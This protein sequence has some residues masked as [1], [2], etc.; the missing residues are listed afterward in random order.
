MG[1]RTGKFTSEPKGLIDQAG[2]LESLSLSNP[3]E[4]AWIEVIH[5]MDSVYADL[6]QSQV[7]L[8]K[9]HD[10]LKEAQRFISS[11]L[12][13]MTEVLI[14]CDIDGVIQQTNSALDEITGRSS[15]EMCGHSLMS[16]FSGDAEGL[17]QQLPEQV[18]SGKSV[19]DCEVSLISRDGEA[20][21]LAVNC[22]SRYNSR[23]KLVG[24][25]LI[26]RPLG[27]LRQAYK[28][29][30]QAHHELRRTQQQLILSEK[31][32][33]LGRLV[34]G[35]AHE[36]NNPISFVFGNMHA[37]KRY[38]RNITTYL[39]A[40]D[41]P[42]SPEAL[43]R[44]RAELNIDKIA[45]DLSPLVEGTLE[46]AERV[47][48]I[49]HDLRRYFSAQEEEAKAFDLT[50]VIR[51]AAQWVLKTSK[52]MP[53]IRF[54]M[55]EHLS[56]TGK[57]RHFHQIIV[58]LVQNSIDVM[59]GMASPEL[60]VSCGEN[61]DGFFASVRDFGPGLSEEFLLHI[62]EPFYTTKPVGKG[63]GLGLYVSY[64]L[65]EEMGGTLKGVNHPEGGAVFTLSLPVEAPD[66]Q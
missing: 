64:V 45:G 59:E 49:V 5:K 23:G 26:G 47:S 15:Q 12:A 3:D 44:L 29:L 10:A 66:G 4:E 35:V 50:A 8:E 20:V 25:V 16:I 42:S 14:V 53:A 58:N 32:A 30:D 51:T 43:N 22:T 62:F 9:N 52:Q 1:Q 46:G 19:M 21:P 48:E 33:A 17:V 31:M 13:S 18:R 11:V 40:L 6:V 39:N 65:C 61:E 60:V 55:P 27:E 37:L 63:T 2:V 28:E 56:I 38:G 34:A 36:L 7:E 54:D 41:G 24:L 57:K